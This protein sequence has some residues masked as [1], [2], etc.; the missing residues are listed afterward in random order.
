MIRVTRSPSDEFLLTELAFDMKDMITYE[1]NTCI[2]VAER[3]QD[4]HRGFFR[5][6]MDNESKEFFIEISSQEMMEAFKRSTLLNIL[7]LAEEAGAETVYICLSKTIQQKSRFFFLNNWLTSS[8]GTHLKKFIFIG[9][10]QLS[11][12]EQSQISM[13]TTHS[14]L[15]YSIVN[16]E[17]DF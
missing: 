17:E 2:L 15:K 5:C 13:T 8:I 10:E 16:K 7:E 6:Y 1:I 4:T 11:Q 12:E 3:Q 9:F 14:L